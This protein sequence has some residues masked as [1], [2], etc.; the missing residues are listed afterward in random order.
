MGKFIKFHEN[1]HK[2]IVVCGMSA[3]FSA[4][5]GTPMAAAFFAIEVVSVGIMHYSALVPSV[6]SAIVAH[7]VAEFL[8]M[9]PESFPVA[10][11][12]DLQPAIFL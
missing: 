9:P 7:F 5:F 6:I 10:I 2:I 8:R 3:G 4:L 12:P 11:V 1:D